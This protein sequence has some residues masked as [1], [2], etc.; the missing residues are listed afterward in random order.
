MYHVPTR[1]LSSL[2]RTTLPHLLSCQCHAHCTCR[3]A[4]FQRAEADKAT[5]VKAAEA[6]AEARYLQGQG[7]SRQRMAILNGLR[8][9]VADF[10]GGDCC[11]MCWG[12]WEGRVLV[13][14]WEGLWDAQHPTTL[15]SV[16]QHT[17]TVIVLRPDLQRCPCLSVDSTLYCL[18]CTVPLSPVMVLH[19]SV[20]YMGTE[21]IH[22]CIPLALGKPRALPAHCR[23]TFFVLSGPPTQLLLWLC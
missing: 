14:W 22:P 20:S 21:S 15:Q 18:P 11:C 23:L 4:A 2:Q 3:E 16:Q 10:S 6:E 13:T 8:D 9:S 1:L 7:I 17:C 5:R 19:D 12:A